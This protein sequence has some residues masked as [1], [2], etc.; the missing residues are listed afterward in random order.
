MK[1]HIRKFWVLLCMGMFLMGVSA[2]SQLIWTNGSANDQSGLGNHGAVHGAT[3]TFNR[4]LASNEI[5][6]LCPALPNDLCIGA[7]ALSDNIYYSE[8]T[9]TATDDVTPSRGVIFKGVWFSYTPL[10][11]GTTTVDT[12]TSDF[13]TVLE[14]M[15]GLCGSLTTIANND[16]G[17]C[18]IQSS[19][20]FV[21]STG[22]TYLICAGGC[23]G[24]SGHLNIRVHNDGIVNLALASGGST[25]SGTTDGVKLE[26][27][28]DGVTTGY[29]GENG[30]GYTLWTPTPGAI[31]LDLKRLCSISSMKLLLWDLDDRYY[32]YKIEASSDHLTWDTIVD[33]T[34]ETDRCRG[35]QD[36]GF[37]P[38]I[39]ARYL[40]LMGTY[41][42]ANVQFHVV[43]WEVYDAQL[44]TL[45]NAERYVSLSGAHVYPFTN[46]M[47]AATNIQAAVD[48]AVEG[49][50]V[51]VTNGVYDTG[52]RTANGAL[53]NRVAIDKPITVR[54]INGPEVTVI[55]GQGP[56]GDA[57]VRCAYVGI[58]A[59]LV[60]FTLT[61]GVTRSSGDSD[62]ERSGGGVWCE[63]SGVLS[64]CVLTGNSAHS[65]GG[66]ACW[67]TLDNC[68]LTGNSASSGGGVCYSMLDN[69]TLIGNSATSGG[70]GM[71][72]SLLLNC[73]LISNSANLGG[74]AYEGKLLNCM[75]TGN[76]ANSGGG[77]YDGTLYNCTLTGNSANLGGGANGGMLYNCIVYYNDAARGAN[78][79]NSTFNYSCTTSDPG[80]LGNIASEPQ[81]ASFSHLAVGSPCRSAGHSHYAIGTDI[82]GEAWR[83]PPS[84]GCDEVVA[85]AITGTLNVS[86]WAAPTNVAVSFPIRFRAGILGRT[87]RSVWD[88]GDGT[89]VSNNPYA[90]HAYA[91]PGMYTVLLRAYNE[92]YPQG[93]TATVTVHVATQAIHYVNLG[94]ATSVA[95]YTSWAT[96][97]TNIQ[98][99]IDAASQ[100]G[101]LVLVSNG[102][103]T[104]GGRVV[105]GALSNRVAMTK[106]VRVR[107][108]NGPA[109]TIIQGA[110]PV[111]DSAVR[112][113]YVG[114][115]AVLEG[116]TLTNGATRSSGDV[117]R[118]QNGGGVWCEGSG[119][120]SNCVLTGNSASSSGGGAYNG[121]FYNCTLSDNSASYE[122]GGADYGTL[123]NCILIGNSAGNGGGVSGSTLYNCTL[124]GNSASGSGGGVEGGTLY[125]CTLTGNSAS[126]GGG[127]GDGTLYNCT[128]IGNSA[129]YNG[130]GAHSSMLYNCIV[131][132]NEAAF[133]ANYYYSIF[134]YSCTTLYPGGSGNIA[135]EP[136]LASFSHLAAGSP[137]E[138]AGHSNYAIGIDIDG[139]TWRAPPSMGCDEV[140][141]GAITGV[142][143]VSASAVSTN[144]AVGFPLQFRA[145]ILGRTTR[146]VWDFGD[147]TVL[148]NKPY[149]LHSYASPGV[150]AV[151][152]QSYNETYPQGITATITVH[153]VVQVIHYV[154][155]GNA[156]PIAPYTS[157]ATAATNIQDALDA[158]N[159]VGA[160]VLVSN[161]IYSTGGRVVYGALSNRVA[162]TK[163]VTVRSVHGPAMTIIQGAGPVGDSAVRC[164]YVGTNAVLEG[165]TLTNGATRSSGYLDLEQSGGGVWCESS[166]VLSNCAISGNSA[167]YDGGGAY[168]GRLYNCMLAGNSA[169]LGGGS[170]VGTLYNCTLTGNS[171]SRG[172]GSSEST[173]YN[174]TLT[175]NSATY[176]GGVHYG[177]LYNCIVYYN[178]AAFGTNYYGSTFNYSC[179]TPYPGGSGNITSEPQLA[180][181][182]HLAVGSPCR[183]A[184]H[185]NYAIGTDIDGETWRAPP[186]M[187]CD[188]VVVGA[189]TGALSVSASAVSTNVA[190][191]FP[192][193][194]RADILGRT[195]RSVWDFGDGTVLSNKPYTLHSC[196]SSGVYAVLLR[197]YNEDYPQGITATVTVHVAAQAI[198]YVKLGNA[199]P[200][201]PY[202]SWATA[203]TNIQDAIDAANQVG[204]LVLVSNGIYSTGGCVVYGALNNRVAITKPVTVRSANGPAMTIIQGAGPVGD[205]AVRCAYVGTNAVLEGF[206]LTSG[207]TCSSGDY[208]RERCGGGVWCE[209]SSV[210]SNCVLTGNLASQSGGG[211]Y[212]GML[213]NCTL[214][215]NSAPGGG[216]V[217]G[218]TLY[219]CTLTDNS[220]SS[221]GGASD[222]TLNNCMLT[223]NSATYGG[224]A[225]DGALNNCTLTGNSAIYYGGGA[226][227]GT[228]Y[229]CTLTGNSASHGGGGAAYGT[230]YQCMLIDNSA[231]IG[232]GAHDGTLYNCTLTGN[233][234]S[235]GGGGAADGTLNNCTLTG[236][237][238]SYGGGGASDGTLNN[239]MLTGNSATYG[240]GAFDGALNNCTLTG[241]SATY[242]GGGA[243]YGTLYNCTLTGNLASYGGGAFTSTLY[244]CIVYYNTASRDSNCYGCTLNFSCTTPNPGGTNNIT[245]EPQFVSAANGDYR[246]LPS[247]PCIDHGINQN[248]MFDAMDLEGNPRILNGTVDMGTYEFFFQ[249]DFKVWI[250]GPYDTNTQKM[251]TA[252]NAAGIIPLTSPYADDPRRVSAIPSNATDWVLFQLR[253]STNNIPFVSKSVFLSQERTLLTDGGTTGLMI[254][255]STGTYYLA[256]K[257]RNHLAVISADPVPFTNQMVSYDF[258]MNAAQYYGGTNGAVQLGPNA[259]GMIA[260]DADGD[261]EILRVDARLY[262]TQT[263]STGYK[264][265]DFNL[266]GVVSNDDLEVFWNS[267]VGRCTMVAQ[268]ETI[269]KPALKIRPPRKTLPVESDYNFSASGGT[270][271]ITWAFVKN[272]SGGTNFPASPTST[273]YRAGI[274]SSCIDVLEAWDSE[275]RLGRAYVN[276]IGAEEVARSGKAIIVAGRKSADD[277]LW[278]TTDYL[279]D[280]A[281]N[282]L[283]YR[284]YGKQHIRYLSPIINQD[285]DGNGQMDD[286]IDLKTT[287]ANAALTFTNWAIGAD[288]LF[289]YL[290]D[291]GGNS[292][293]TGYFRLNEFDETL[294]A[295]KLGVW[296]DDLQNAYTTT[297]TVLIDC[298]YAGSFLDKLAYTGVASRIVIAACGTNE[299]TYFL[300]GGSVSF[301][302]AFFG[303]VMRGDNVEQAW[304]VAS[305]AM[306]GYQNAFWKDKGN[307]AVDLYLGASFVAGKDIPQ[308]GSVMGNQLLSKTTAATLWAGDVVSVYSIQQVWCLVIPPGHRSNSENPVTDL[309]ELDL[310]YDSSSG[311]YQGRYEGFSEEGSYKVLFYAEDVWGSVSPP[312]QSYVKQSS[313]NERVILVAGGPTNLANRALIDG[314]ARHAYRTF[315]VRGLDSEKIWYLNAVT[316]GDVDGDGTNDVNALISLANLA[317]AITNWAVSADAL[318]VYL[319]GDGT[320]QTLRL[321]ETE[322]LDANSLNRWLSV[323]SISNEQAKVN[324]IMDFSGSGGFLPALAASNRVCIASCG[325]DQRAMCVN[326][327][328][329]SFSWYF[330]NRLVEGFTFYDA[331]VSAEEG[332]YLVSLRPQGCQ[333]AQLD[334]NGDGQYESK[335]EG[336]LARRRYIGAAFMTGADTPTIGSVTPDTWLKGA[337]T[338]WLWASDVMDMDGISNV[339]CIITPPAWDGTSDLPE[340]NLTWNADSNRYEALYPYFTEPGKYTLTFHAVDN[341]GAISMPRQAQVL[342]SDAY[343]PDNTHI[344]AN[345]FVVGETQ[346]HNFHCAGDHDWVKFY[347]ISNY[348]FN[349]MTTHLGTNVDTV[350]DVYYE[351]AD[352]TLTK[353]IHR[354]RGGVGLDQG[355]STALNNPDPGMYYVQVSSGNSNAWGVSSAYDLTITVPVGGDNLMIIV[356][357]K[358]HVDQSPPGTVVVVD[359]TNR[360]PLNGASS[361]PLS[362]PSG[363][364]KV[365]VPVV[366]G[367]LPEEDPKQPDQVNNKNS[368]LYGNPKAVQVEN[369]NWR[370]AVFQFVPYVQVASGS[371]VRDQ[372]TQ[373]RL[374]NT[375]IAFR[376]TSG[377]ISNVWYDGYPNNTNCPYKSHWYSQPDGTFPTNVWLPTVNYDLTLTKPNYSN[378]IFPR[379]IINP[380]PGQTTNLATLYLGPLDANTNR[381]ADSWEERYFGA[382]TPLPTVDTDGDGHNNREEYLLG[383]DPTNRDSMLKVQ[384]SAQDTNGVTLI[385]PV[386]NGRTYDILTSDQL[387]SGL[388]TQT[389]F[390]P[391]EA[392]YGQTQMQWT[393]TNTADQTNR[394]YRVMVPVP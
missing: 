38:A 288:R 59:V 18:D 82:D 322:V 128:L 83:A 122:G 9:A 154:K 112:C 209:S 178:D 203:A 156:T 244:N 234:A 361:L 151:L 162:I 161:G 153:V 43:E 134:S 224:G 293:G 194:F 363:I 259:W 149:T 23:G 95:P 375:K 358:L 229:N 284:G 25:I 78:Y 184:G 253:K 239:C 245:D 237:S 212:W 191:G 267:N 105:H 303:G 323:F 271:T 255:A 198:H 353:M 196:A 335:N 6:T 326:R 366:A 294:T 301:S 89:V 328:V 269:L 331:F 103:Y 167:S 223:G 11:S 125:N 16:N 68:A 30:Y 302:G 368:Y 14:V 19:L 355:E 98:D 202:T 47:T 394:F 282:T 295:A 165:F 386:A 279:A 193:R 226:Y 240:G 94:N 200:I 317:N 327:G 315:Q 49:D 385:W 311:R 46:W 231:Y 258:T 389:P 220:A 8:D 133:G 36:I 233:S 158:A 308:I 99:A 214:T 383:T 262:D 345:A 217:S 168:D 136:Q 248:W 90:L 241:N 185:S 123:Y 190:V 247:S 254:E 268:G 357:D 84:M 340:T 174:C 85:G 206:T 374:S 341:H 238:A 31:T 324:V 17:S 305:N 362:L 2:Q 67:G 277:P 319:L 264:R 55:K 33:R 21:C 124:T 86:A 4:A 285:V 338:L 290:V 44:E 121:T 147:G 173:L 72:G 13:D 356:V 219:N 296:L 182:S 346:S 252:L 57:A 75:L 143:S 20:S 287:L 286:D 76:S 61:N 73:T 333:E 337:N 393:I 321:N 104:T 381:L 352:N 152:L 246:L 243:Y 261:G 213:Y 111:G 142:L 1:Q 120:L 35:W 232:G 372:W 289:V 391:C 62:H 116:F 189:I 270:G 380:T 80:D 347:A 376:A 92:S 222:G 266:D 379:T 373:E 177:T 211:A 163:P 141:A 42:S 7:I 192:I 314:L 129:S 197:A 81:L 260:G 41:N 325:S 320:N 275:D 188:Q 359:E 334:D 126:S 365:A 159:Q 166:G 3:L 91:S 115:N 309:S 204:A 100:I 28:I 367:Y 218:S 349:I 336:R 299:P 216:G 390:D 181:F 183:S 51:W 109:M 26:S 348:S 10:A 155:L 392:D 371:V 179:T 48:A 144:V 88:F 65:C 164:A 369:E 316:N 377:I 52:G 148:S 292:S 93:I 329:V 157:W 278:P 227:Y 205:S 87:T 304:V 176:G 199:T 145:N 273:V 281:F 58:N 96:A 274:T 230:L 146:S 180:S 169:D 250:Q 201:A 228:L 64:N 186:S 27:L 137:C 63:S 291:H 195:T 298:C 175:G 370:F 256:I 382:N 77:V 54:S 310:T 360:Y 15:S 117:D 171:A 12:C 342:L 56:L 332:I 187:G 351:N 102:I 160:L 283:L 5:W 313:Y 127:V 297:V 242:G 225:F 22:V 24:A 150:Y 339:F 384:I 60:G 378:A 344:E 131:Y 251:T 107:S 257:H 388:W 263:N 114:T 32:R 101:A 106:P 50:T 71:S 119:V 113:A 29:D 236:N 37:N 132:Y 79:D 265:A 70:G 110:G 140:V 130:G 300:A 172:G 118:E 343:E 364:H 45:R 135:S 306:F 138:G 249:G 318:T 307:S 210:L 108:V 34:A 354:D 312:R 39:Q 276:V 97:A 235:Y 215:G 139:E 69:C 330:L 208:Y 221:G 40:R 170:S 74:G 53:T 66:G 280:L 350:L 387:T 272:P 207:A